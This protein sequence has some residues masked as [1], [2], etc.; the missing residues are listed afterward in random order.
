MKTPKIPMKQLMLAGLMAASTLGFSQ[1]IIQQTLM[2]TDD[3]LVNC[4][5]HRLMQRMDQAS[6]GLMEA[7]NQM[8]KGIATDHQH[9]HKKSS[10]TVLQIPV[11]FHIVYND[12]TVNLP[13]SVIQDQIRVLNESYRRHN[14]DTSNTRAPFKPIVADAE[15][16]FV[17]A[18]KDPN[19]N[20]TNGITRTYSNIKYFGGIL[21]YDNTQSQQIQTWVAD[22]LYYNYFRITQDSLDGK[23]AWDYE[24][25]VNVWIGD[26]RILEP[27]LNNFEELVFFGLATPPANHPNWPQAVYDELGGFQ[28]GI[29]M[30]YPVIGSNNPNTF[31]APY[32]SYNALVRTGKMLVHETGHYLGLRHIWGDGN[33]TMDDHVKDTPRANA[34]SQYNCNHVTNSCVDTINGTDLPNMVENYMDYSSGGCQNSFT[35]GQV[36]VMRT[37]IQTYRPNLLS[38]EEVEYTAAKNIS[39]YPNPTSGELNIKFGSTVKDAQVNVRSIDGKLLKTVSLNHTDMA[40]I[41][42]ENQPGLYLI[43]VTADGQSSTFK[44]IKQ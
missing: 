34:A 16:E 37:V 6:P 2:S 28:Q 38:N 17:L 13:D 8:L 42:L 44:V 5:S 15:I 30:H 22:S 27:K 35:Q 3:S 21:P 32:Q 9:D 26:L 10:G 18:T 11:V 40:A 23:S 24:R 39:Y 1:G 7:S 20:P 14:A 12:T 19:G 41:S 33:C 43:Q 4:G 36:D 29:L 25:Y 31:P